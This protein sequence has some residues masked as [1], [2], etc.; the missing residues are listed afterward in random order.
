MNTKRVAGS[1]AGMPLDAMSDEQLAM[2]YVNGNN[3]AFDLLLDRNKTRLFSYIFFVVRNR[4]V[5]NDLFQDTFVK[6]IMRLQVGDYQS[7]GKFGA[8]ITR[9]AHNVIMDWFRSQQ[10][11]SIVDVDAENDMTT[12]RGDLA[13]YESIETAFVNNQ[14]FADVK[15]LM[16]QLPPLQRE[17]VFMRFYQDLSFKEIAEATGVSINTSLGRMR[18]AVMNMRKMIHSHNLQMHLQ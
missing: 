2:A 6:V 13:T 5:A 11:D 9:I 7:I 8:W 12:V 15:N 4:D 18:Y 16:E 14:I 3:K 1:T 10:G 17:V